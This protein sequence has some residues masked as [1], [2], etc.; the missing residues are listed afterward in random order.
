MP[1][2]IIQSATK[3]APKPVA[4]EATPIPT[5]VPVKQVETKATPVEVPKV[6]VKAE[7]EPVVQE[8]SVI[9][10]E[11]MQIYKDLSEATTLIRNITQRMKC[12]EREVKK[13]ARILHKFQTKASKR[14]T[15]QAPRGFAKPTR[16]SDEM[17]KFFGVAIGTEMARTEAAKLIIKYIQDKQLVNTENKKAF[18]PDKALQSILSP[19]EDKHKNEDGYTYFNLQHYIGKNFGSAANTIVKN[20]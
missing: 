12:L 7:I 3:V 17:A 18:N 9:A 10:T 6:E 1:K 15:S 8:N 20:I 13:E 4:K 14:S 16:I 5:P 19:L 2:K 11:M